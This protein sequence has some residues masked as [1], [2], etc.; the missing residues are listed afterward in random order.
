MKRLSY[1]NGFFYIK[2]ALR[3]SRSQ[4]IKLISI[5]FS[6]QFQLFWKYPNFYFFGEN[7]GTNQNF[8]AHVL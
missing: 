3:Q 5:L 1:F 2:S 7:P 6:F 4:N 8:I